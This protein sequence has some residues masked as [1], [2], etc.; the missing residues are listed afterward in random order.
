MVFVFRRLVETR[1]CP[2]CGGPLRHYITELGFQLLAC[3]NCWFDVVDH[4]VEKLAFNKVRQIAARDRQEQADRKT[5]VIKESDPQD[6]GKEIGRETMTND[7]E[8]FYQPGRTGPPQKPRPGEV[9]F[10]FA[11]ES[12]QARFRC[13]LRYHDEYGVEAQFFKDGSLLIARVFA[14]K[15]L[16]VRWAEEERRFIEK[17]GV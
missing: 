7:D 12:D 5:H 10:A 13:D 16:A 2:Q 17:G 14:T 9:L 6:V 1:I 15:A 3:M 4:P 8:P 11:R